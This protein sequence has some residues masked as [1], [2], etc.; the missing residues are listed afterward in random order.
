MRDC[1]AGIPRWTSR[2]ESARDDN[3]DFLWPFCPRGAP[4]PE[5]LEP[6][7]HSKGRATSRLGRTTS[8]S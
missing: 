6:G 2:M 8:W 7:W 1:R 3:H 5:S 4:D